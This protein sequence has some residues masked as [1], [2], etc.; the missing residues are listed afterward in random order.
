MQYPDLSID[1]PF[2]T[3][4]DSH[5]HKVLESKMLAGLSIIDPGF[6][7]ETGSCNGI[8]EIQIGFVKMKY[9]KP[10]ERE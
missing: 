1:L 9:S 2:F 6:R 3:G 10:E 4:I 5:T 7:D 8:I